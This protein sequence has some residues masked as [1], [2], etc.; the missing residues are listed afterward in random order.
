MTLNSKDTRGP[1][2]SVLASVLETIN[3]PWWLSTTAYL[4]IRSESHLVLSALDK[5]L[6]LSEPVSC[7]STGDVFPLQ[8]SLGLISGA[9]CMCPVRPQ[10]L[11][12]NAYF[13][14]TILQEM[15]LL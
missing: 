9:L 14:E 5:Y 6:N 7:H 2:L 1:A 4:L 3:P 13:P 8:E 10:I 12:K 11:H 15:L